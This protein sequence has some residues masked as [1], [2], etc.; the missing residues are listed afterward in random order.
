MKRH[1]LT[2]AI[3]TGLTVLTAIAKYAPWLILIVVAYGMIY[4]VAD[5]ILADYERATPRGGE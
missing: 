2:V 5:T 3:I 1:L 4:A